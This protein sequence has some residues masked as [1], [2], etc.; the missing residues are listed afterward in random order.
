MVLVGWVFE[1]LHPQEWDKCSYKRDTMGLPNP[2]CDVNI[3]AGAFIYIH[4]G[5]PASRAVRNNFLLFIG[6][7]VG[8]TLLLQ[9][10]Q[11]K[12][13]INEEKSCN[14]FYEVNKNNDFKV[15]WEHREKV[16]IPIDRRDDKSL[17]VWENGS[18]R[19]G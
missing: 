10:E 1:R 9:P 15:C 17:H 11:N 3:R 8:G 19:R 5:L 4:V 13:V 12:T 16:L 2:F 18:S 6:H 7:P 14:Y